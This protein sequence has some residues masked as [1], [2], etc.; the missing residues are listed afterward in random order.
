MSLRV[1]S[2]A[3][4]NLYLDV[5]DQRSDGYNNIE[6]LFQTISLCDTLTIAPAASGISLT[7]NEP[8]LPTGAE[9]LV[10]RAAM[11]LREQSGDLPGVAMHLRKRI[12]VA[13]GLA[14]GSGNAAAALVGLD[15]FWGLG[16]GAEKLAEIALGLGSDVPYC[17]VGGPALATGRGEEI[18]VLPADLAVHWLVLIHPPLGISAASVYRHPRLV[19]SGAPRVDGRTQRFRDAIGRYQAGDVAAMVFNGM[20]APVFHDHP[21]L[22]QWRDRLLALGC[23]AAAMSGSGPTLFGLCADEAEA[24]RVAGAFGEAPATVAHTVARG[25]EIDSAT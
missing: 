9:N 7:C 21:T 13:A 4:I 19:R 18:E 22:L 1:T 8:E 16:L 10:V 6:T 24:I 14:G 2:F 5:I 17:L 15:R 12:P 25:V 20:E 23:S 3:K 11:A